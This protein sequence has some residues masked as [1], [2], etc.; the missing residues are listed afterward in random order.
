MTQTQ[1]QLN[2]VCEKALHMVYDAALTGEST[3]SEENTCAVSLSNNQ[4]NTN[5][6]RI[7]QSPIELHSM[8][9]CN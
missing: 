7:G 2:K 5:L 6:S 1:T 8:P 9:L 3:D 4:L